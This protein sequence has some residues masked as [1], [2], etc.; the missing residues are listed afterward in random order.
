MRIVGPQ[1]VSKEKE[2]STLSDR[3]PSSSEPPPK[4]P[5]AAESGVDASTAA[6]VI[7]QREK[8]AE[9]RTTAWRLTDSDRL[10]LLVS[11]A[12]ILVFT[13]MHWA[14]ISGWGQQE[15]EITRLPQRE[16]D[17]RIDINEATW[18]EWMQLEQIGEILARRIVADRE[19]NGP[20]RSVEE[21]TRVKGIGPKT[22][23][24]IR[25]WLIVGNR[26]S[27]GD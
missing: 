4:T 12:L 27:P 22:L 1:S 23:E 8:L 16:F 25:P 26:N 18:V 5:Q 10:V 19:Q 13:V 11:G 2:A 20:F 6:T 15:I 7:E 3:L 21:V 9:S 24:T 17:Y 14:K